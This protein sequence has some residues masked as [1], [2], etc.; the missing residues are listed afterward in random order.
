MMT[1]SRFHLFAQPRYGSPSPSRGKRGRTTP[2]S[3]ARA[4]TWQETLGGEAPRSRGY[5]LCVRSPPDAR[6]GK[7]VGKPALLSRSLGQS[8]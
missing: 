5:T 6:R 1:K 4:V 8:R 2:Y 7:N 3:H